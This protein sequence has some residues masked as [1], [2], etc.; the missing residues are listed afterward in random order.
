MLNYNG[1]CFLTGC[2]EKTEWMLEWFL[3][4]YRKHND[5]PILVADFGMS[6]E[7]LARLQV[8]PIVSEI[9]KLPPVKSGGW[10]YKPTALLSCPYFEKCWLDTDIEVLGD[11]S[12]VFDYIEDE[13]LAMVEDRPWS[14]RRGEKWHNSGVI[15]LRGNPDILQRWANECR[16][17]SKTGDQEVLHSMINESPLTRLKYIVDLPNI[18]NWLRIQIIDG[19][20]SNKKLAMHWTGQ[21]GK[22]VIWKKIYNG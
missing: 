3:K 18:Y 7:M 12:G 6:N 22:N 16:R 8:N 10:F 19:Q 15:A 5:T 4:N 1:R 21:H 14:A 20:D 17:A 13:K 9:V 2:D 11:L